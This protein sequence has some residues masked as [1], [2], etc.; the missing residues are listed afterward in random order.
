MFTRI[1]YSIKVGTNKNGMAFWWRN[2]VETILVLTE[3][4]SSLCILLTNYGIICLF[5]TYLLS[6]DVYAILAH[7]R[8]LFNGPG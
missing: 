5:C 6:N 7:P 1:V 2:L 4:I 8:T 3:V